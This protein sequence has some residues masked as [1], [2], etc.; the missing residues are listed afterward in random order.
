MTPASDASRKDLDRATSAFIAVTAH[1]IHTPVASIKWQV[2]TLLAGDIGELTS[3]QRESLQA[4]MDAAERLNDLSRALLYVFELEKDMPMVKLQEADV[5]MLIER[6]VKN[7]G[8]L[9]KERN[10]HIQCE[11]PQTVVN[12]HVDSELAFVILRTL[13]EN[14]ILYSPTKSV[15][16]VRVTERASSTDICVGDKGCGIPGEFHNLVFT[17][18][19]R[20][21]N[22]KRVWTEGSGLGLYVAGEIAKRTGGEITFESEEGKGSTFCWRIPKRKMGRQPWEKR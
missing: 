13:L 18:F 7:L 1:K 3:N 11:R 20:A 19:F 12:V 4:V 5:Y 6:V 17:K 14:A 10:V 15:V 21:P 2:E 16:N 22:G 8:G 9:T